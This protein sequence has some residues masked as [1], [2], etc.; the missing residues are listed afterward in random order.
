MACWD[1]PEN[2]LI[3]PMDLV[4]IIS[5][6]TIVVPEDS[7]D[8]LWHLFASTDFRLTH[9]VSEDGIHWK[10][11]KNYFWL[12]HTQWIFKEGNKYYL[13]YQVKRFPSGWIN[14]RIS[15]DLY[16]WSKP[17]KVL[18][19]TL[20]W[21]KRQIGGVVRNPC[22]VKV[23]SKYYLYYSGGIQ[24]FRDLGWGEPK[25]IGLAISDNILGPYEKLK[26]PIISPDKNHPY[27]NEG[28]GGL[29]VYRWFGSYFIGFENGVYRDKDRKVH[30]A[31]LLLVSKDGIKWHDVTPLILP[32]DGWKKV[33]VWQLDAIPRGDEIWIYYNARN[34]WIRGIEQIGLTI[35]KKEYIKSLVENKLRE[36][37]E[38]KEPIR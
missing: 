8:G 1:H 7:P 14:V 18:W 32:S 12:N 27:R 17:K 16:N 20:K 10:N 4:Q 22:V 37:G 23:D 11:V 2:P 26:D 31:I 15:E 33:F 9:W 35:C 24:F 28:C 30:S 34:G 29:R 3:P 6:P 25:H 5:D 36:I 19:A 13:F 38:S 21:E